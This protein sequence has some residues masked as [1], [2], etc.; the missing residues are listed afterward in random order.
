M[1]LRIPITLAVLVAIRDMSLDGMALVL[2]G[3]GQG[4]VGGGPGS[5]RSARA[6]GMIGIR[7]GAVLLVPAT[8]G[9]TDLHTDLQDEHGKWV[10]TC[11]GTGFGLITG[12]IAHSVYNDCMDKARAAGLKPIN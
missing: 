9:C 1:Q 7:I 8:V 4:G 11:R 3:Q 5:G 12:L 2:Q 10:E 6:G